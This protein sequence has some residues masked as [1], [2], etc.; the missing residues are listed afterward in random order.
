MAEMIRV[1]GQAVKKA[2][3][4]TEQVEFAGKTRLWPSYRVIETE[5]N[6]DER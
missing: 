5:G 3:P 2:L 4:K 1:I 6:R